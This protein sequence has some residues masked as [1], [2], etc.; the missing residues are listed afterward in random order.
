MAKHL[1][2]KVILED[3]DGEPIANLRTKNL[4]VDRE[5]ADV[6]DD[7]SSGWRE[8]LPEPAQLNVDM[9]ISGVLANDALRAK[10]ISTDGLVGRV[11]VYPDGGK[12]TGDFFLQNYTELHEYNAA[13]TF[14]GSLQSSGVITYTPPA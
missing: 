2:R 13:S 4:S 11:L 5:P 6:T 3:E 7:D 1:G 12:L 8:L 14:D 9:S 10:A